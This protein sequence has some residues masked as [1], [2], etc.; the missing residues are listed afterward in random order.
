VFE[1]LKIAAAS[2]WEEISSV[3]LPYLRAKEYR[4]IC[5]LADANIK[6]RVSPIDNFVVLPN[7]K[8][9]DLEHL[10]TW[11]DGVLNGQD[12]DPTD[13]SYCIDM[14]KNQYG[15]FDA[16]YQEMENVVSYLQRRYN[17]I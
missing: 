17:A 5:I 11:F 6:R 16:T 3:L 15:H 12:I 14:L 2:F 8:K 13:I 9:F 7:P 4:F 10:C 1:K